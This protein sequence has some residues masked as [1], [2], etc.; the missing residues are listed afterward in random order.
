MNKSQLIWFIWYFLWGALKLN[1]KCPQIRT[2]SELNQPF[3]GGFAEAYLYV[4]L[5]DMFK[6]GIFL[7]RLFIKIWQKPDTESFDMRG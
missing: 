1:A 7:L 2:R 6:L 4:I 3:L 5:K